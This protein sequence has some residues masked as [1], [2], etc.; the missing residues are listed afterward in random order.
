M[1]LVPLVLIVTSGQREGGG[2]ERDT[3][4]RLLRMHPLVGPD[5]GIRTVR[6][7]TT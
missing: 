7:G 5:G 6:V 2:G 3:W 1:Y 4:V